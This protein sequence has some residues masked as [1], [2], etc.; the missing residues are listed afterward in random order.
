MTHIGMK[1]KEL[2]KK[3]D[4]TQEKLADYLKVSF[5]AVS[6]WET[7]AA[8]PD[9]SMIV[10]LA[11]LLGVTTDELFGLND[12]VE[13]QRQKEFKELYDETWDFS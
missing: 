11:R 2:R 6:N 13:D 4:I 3:K 1:I 12:Y 8:S 7:G 5:Q 10:P 9:L